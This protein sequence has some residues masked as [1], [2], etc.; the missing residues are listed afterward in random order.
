MTLWIA[1]YGVRMLAIVLAMLLVEFA[2][3]FFAIEH[4]VNRL[5]WVPVSYALVAYAGYDTVS[6]MP[7][8]WG[9]VMSGAIAG[10]VNSASWLIGSFVAEGRFRMPAEAEPLLVATSL[11]MASLIGAII[12]GAAGVIARARRRQRARRSAIRKLAYTAMDEAPDASEDRVASTTPTARAHAPVT[13][14]AER[15]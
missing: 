4:D 13:H 6:R 15:P 8:L 11:L 2:A 10:I 1:R 5:Y 9:L 12:G 7:L 3:F 14:G